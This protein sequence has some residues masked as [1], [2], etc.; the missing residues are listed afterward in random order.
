M[1][2]VSCDYCSISISNGALSFVPYG[3]CELRHSKLADYDYFDMS[4]PLW[5]V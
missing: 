2:R 5:G 1:G 3:A 4:R